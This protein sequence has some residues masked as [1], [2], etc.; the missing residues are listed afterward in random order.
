MAIDSTVFRLAQQIWDYHR[1]NLPLEKADFI[2][3]LGSYDLRVAERCADLYADN[4]APF[5]IFS[6][7]SRQLDQCRMG[8]K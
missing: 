1:L 4:W 2:V 3:G 8:S 7:A 6:G 5:I